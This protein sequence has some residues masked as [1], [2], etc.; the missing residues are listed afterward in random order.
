[1]FWVEPMLGW[2]SDTGQE[3]AVIIDKKEVP[4]L[5]VLNRELMKVLQ[6]AAST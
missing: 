6:V 3:A 5:K 2:C 1:M 4:S